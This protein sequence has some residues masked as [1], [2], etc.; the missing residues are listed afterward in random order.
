AEW[1]HNASFKMVKNQ[2]Y[3]NKDK[4]ALHEINMPYLMRD[5]SSEFNMFKD[6][7]FA[8][9]RRIGKEQMLDAQK[10]KMEIRK[11]SSGTVWYFQFNTTRK[12]TANKTFRK[13]IQ[14]AMDRDEFAKQVY[15]I[16]GTK[17]AYGI[18]PDFMPGVNKRYGDEY[19]VAF[20]D[21]NLKLAKE[22]LE[23]A[24]KELGIEKFPKLT[25]L[26]SEID[27][28]RRDMAYFQR[29][30]KEKLGIELELD[31]QSFKVRLER[32]DKKDFDIVNSGWGPDYFDAMT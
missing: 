9:I 21:A 19:S 7:K 30:F 12:F 29:Y 15:G 1:K 16:P 18:I 22:Y 26:A 25:V 11:Y 31:F 8:I 13:A 3:W 27:T 2:A 5:Y 24:K 4:I 17:P 28:V 14:Y 23:K 10:Q 6:D 20:E 32:T